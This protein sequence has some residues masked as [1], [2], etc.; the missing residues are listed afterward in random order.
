MRAIIVGG[1]D[2]PAETLL[3]W[4]QSVED[5]FLVAADG[6]AEYLH[7]IG[8]LPRYLIGD[9]DSI[10]AQTLAW[11]RRQ[12]ACR[13]CH[14]TRQSD[15]DIEKCLTVLVD[16]GVTEAALCAISGSRLDHTLSNLA[17][18]L[19]WSAKVSLAL[20]SGQS[21][22]EVVR[23]NC[24]F[25]TSPGAV[26]SLYAFDPVIRVTTRGLTYPLD[27]EP[28]MFGVRESTSNTASAAQVQLVVQGGPVFLI[29]SQE[30]VRRQGLL[31][32]LAARSG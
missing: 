5:S 11:Y 25:P 28:L 7:R 26:I 14:L 19:R 20:F 4:L 31:E 27:D 22:L 9:F 10:S 15:T 23:Q 24:V 17:L 12:P 6:G 3:D 32:A 13:I 21:V 8:R 1:G 29:R 16:E 30:E 2:P 18:A